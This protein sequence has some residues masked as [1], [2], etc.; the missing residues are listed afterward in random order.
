MAQNKLH[1]SMGTG[2][3]A[4]QRKRKRDIG[5]YVDVTEA[6]LWG[7][8]FQHCSNDVIMCPWTQQVLFH[9][10]SVMKLGILIREL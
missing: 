5:I 7:F 6:K 3:A 8:Y 1:L 2:K 10:S 4:L 9:H